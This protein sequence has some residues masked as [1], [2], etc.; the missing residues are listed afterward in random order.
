MSSTYILP[1]HSKL[2]KKENRASGVNGGTQLDFMFYQIKTRLLVAGDWLSLE[3]IKK[4][5]ITRVKDSR[6]IYQFDG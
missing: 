1:H 5:N 3:D 4:V 2:T 6:S